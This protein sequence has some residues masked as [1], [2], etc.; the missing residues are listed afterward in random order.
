MD[1]LWTIQHSW[2]I[3][4]LPLIGA[5]IAGL[6]GA[7]FL[8]QQSHWPIWLGVG[9]SAVIS[10]ALLFQTIGLSKHH[11]ATNGK[12]SHAA[13]AEGEGDQGLFATKDIYTWASVGNPSQAGTAERPQQVQDNP[14]A[15]FEVKAG[16]FFDPLTITMLCVVTGIGFLITVFSAGYM[17]GEEGYWRFFAYLGLFIFMMTCLVMGNNLIMLYLGWEG[18][19]LCSYL[20]IGYYYEKPAAREAAKKA[21]LVNRVGDFGFGIGIMLSFLAFGTI[22]YFGSGGPG[23]H[24][25]LLELASSTNL[26]GFQQHLLYWIPFCLMLGAFGK[27]AQFPLYVWLPDAMEGPTPVSALI[28]AATMV[29]A[30]VYM[31][32]RCGPL[33]VQNPDAMKTIAAVGAFTAILAASIALRQFDLKKVFAYSTISQLGF[34]FVGVAVLAPVAGV[35]HLV[36]HAFFKALLFLS[37]GVVMHAMAGELDMRKMSGIRR[38]LPLTNIVILIGCLALAGFPPFSG[39]FSKD[40]IV[41]AAMHN[42]ALGA[43]GPIV[44]IILLV[45]AFLTA[46]YTFRLYFR[47][48]MGPL[49]V[50]QPAPAHGHGHEPH[51]EAAASQSAIET[52]TAPSSGVDVGAAHHGGHGQGDGHHNHEPMIMMA[53]LILLAIGALCAGAL[54]I[55]GALGNFLGQSPSLKQTYEVATRTFGQIA[56]EPFGQ[57]GGAPEASPMLLMVI[58]AIISAA[59]IALAYLMHLKDRAMADRVA[60]G[61]GPITSLIENKYWVDQIYQVC[62]VEVM[63]LIGKIDYA[64][65]TYIVDLFLVNLPGWLAQ[66][67]GFV[68]KLVVQQGFLQGYAGFMLFGVAL[69][70][71]VVFQAYAVAIVFGI[72]VAL[73]LTISAALKLG[74]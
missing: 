46:Y 31:I 40:E 27:S 26:S 62:V 66:A 42:R 49:V 35:F 19:G 58:S 32:A 45:T 16:F 25:G 47:V 38:V 70:L 71:L 43:T 33:F 24:T 37:S 72:V 22:S 44:G 14:S 41:G 18:V 30:G 12:E 13:V 36:T 39:F 10:I 60:R 55:H 69:I 61:L 8:R 53:P 73:L 1:S 57:E 9:A 48:F 52:H 29:T 50:P 2:L 20:L 74:A 68:L 3:P 6:F 21:F 56:S 28:H 67:W 63:R 17:K 54:A 7:K 51:E 11:E 65:D 59:G 23:S 5:A 64:I 4:L 34:M 15:Y